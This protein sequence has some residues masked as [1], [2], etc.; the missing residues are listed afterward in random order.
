[1]L[2]TGD[3]PMMSNFLDA[4][5]DWNPQL[6]REIKGRFKPVNIII[7]VTCS[8]LLQLVVFLMQVNRVIEVD[9]YSEY[10]SLG[11]SESLSQDLCPP[12]S[13][14][15]QL[16][17]RDTWE[18][19]FLI[20]SVIFIFTLLVVGTYILINDLAKEEQRGTLNFIRLSPQ[21][22]Q[23]ILFGKMLGVPSLV[24]LFIIL[25]VP[26]HLWSGIAANI[27]LTNIISYYAILL[28]SCYF[29]YSFAILFGLFSRW[30]SS[31]QPWLGSVAVFSFLSMTAGLISSSYN[32][33]SNYENPLV[34]FRLLAP[35]EMVNYLFPNLF[36]VVRYSRLNSLAISQLEFFYIPVGNSLFSL[37]GFHLL[38]YAIC[39]HGI[40]QVIKRIFGYVNHTI[41]SKRQSYCLMV[42]CQ[43][44][45]IG[46]SAQTSERE[47]KLELIVTQ[48][49]L[50]IAIFLILIFA[51][52]PQRQ[53]LQDWARY[54]H[55][56]NVHKSL[57][58]DLIYGEKSPAIVAIAINL[59][60]ALIP[61]VIWNFFLPSLESDWLNQTQ[62]FQAITLSITIVMIYA[63]IAQLILSSKSKK[64]YVWS[65]TTL[66]F[67]M[68]FSGIVPLVLGDYNSTS[69][70]WLF[71]PFPWAGLKHSTNATVYLAILTE[72][73]IAVLLNFQLNRQLKILGES[74]SKAL[75]GGR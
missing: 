8:L 36:H 50:N 23:S 38:N 55:Q 63:G 67:L 72:F 64:R 49:L 25:S 42:Y 70:I 73:T 48:I 58:Q 45:F 22:E 41:I 54:R 6:F 35:W 24:Y 12:E 5:G 69:F 62:C 65:G 44:F 27:A 68:L 56:N 9:K 1:V 61:L 71:S 66:I 59:A 4:I 31:F 32:Y 21:T 43:V 26:L 20:F 15:W 2:L 13:I 28:A 34:W 17:R 46:L 3:F 47:S 37:L 39:T 7:T 19:F 74:S 57:W 30:F 16:W 18:H 14:N 29:F 53:T 60:I 75:L 11:K 10:C 33:H 40:W 52:S 51:L